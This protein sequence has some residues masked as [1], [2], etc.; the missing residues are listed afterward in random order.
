MKLNVGQLLKKNSIPA[1]WNHFLGFFSD[2]PAS[3]SSFFRL[4][5]TEFSSNPS[6][7]LVYTYFGLISV[8]FYSELFF[9]L[10]ES[11]T[12]I[13][14]KSVFSIFSVSSSGSNFSSQ[15]KRIYYDMWKRVFSSVLL[16]R[17]NV[18]LTETIIKIKV[19][20]FLIE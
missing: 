5:E 1:H 9:L 15:W 17:V 4:V 6:S 10:L 8:C 16:F 2:I 20:P 11:I 18:L 19:K 14:C 13:R 12:E 7:R 3:G